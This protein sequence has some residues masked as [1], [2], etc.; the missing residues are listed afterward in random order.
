MNQAI[1]QIGGVL[2]VA[3]AVV[4]AGGAAP[5]IGDFTA[6]GLWMAG[7]AVATAVL[8]APVDTRPR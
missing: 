4:V 2:G 8:C 1:R 7:L 6:I 3:I 5:T